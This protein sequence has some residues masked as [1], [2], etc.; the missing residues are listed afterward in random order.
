MSTFFKELTSFSDFALFRKDDHY[1]PVPDDWWVIIT[2]V[3]GSTQAVREGRYRDVNT[4]GAATIVAATRAALTRDFPFVFGGDGATL[5]VPPEY[6]E[7]VKA[8]LLG[9]KALA[10]ENFALDLRV[11]AV[12]VE[13]LTGAG[14]PLEVGRFA[15]NPVLAQA[16]IRGAGLIWAEHLIKSEPERYEAQSDRVGEPDLASLSCR[17]QPIPSQRG[18]V[19]ALLVQAREGQEAAYDELLTAFAEIFP[20]GL[21]SLNP[22]QATGRNAYHTTVENLRGER[23]YHTSAFSLSF[24]RRALFIIVGNFII[25]SRLTAGVRSY[26]A[27]TASHSDFRKF[28]E[29]LRMVID[30][31]EDE[32]D[33]V[34]EVLDGLYRAG[35]IAYGTHV[36][37][38]ALMTCFVESLQEGGHM[39]FLDAQDGGYTAAAVQL[40]QQ[41]KEETS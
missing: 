35:K 15:L 25:Q 28:D 9:L 13:E 39:H 38:H 18:Q 32:I 19:L 33:R 7:E 5:L 6:A 41:L 31:T 3:K 36:T 4:L 21:E 1:Q 2:D 22:A 11:G 40:K 23:R 34:H 30:C 37:S 20:E 8:R 24:I 12:L 17:W 14:K 26:V 10:R 27:D 29:T 16:T